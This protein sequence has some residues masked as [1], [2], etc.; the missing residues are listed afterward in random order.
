MAIA[1]PSPIQL[2]SHPCPEQAVPIDLVLSNL[3]HVQNDAWSRPINT[4]LIPRDED[5]LA[6][7]GDDPSFTHRPLV[8]WLWAA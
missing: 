1:V 8:L 3:V 7:Y 6:V 4:D 2:I 5:G